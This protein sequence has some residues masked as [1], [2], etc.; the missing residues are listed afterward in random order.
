M[1]TKSEKKGINKFDLER[2][3]VAKLKNLHV[4]KGGGG[5]G[6]KEET[7]TLG[8]LKDSSEYCK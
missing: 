5:N 6:S 1:K 8:K 2:F 4:I 7:G 3:K